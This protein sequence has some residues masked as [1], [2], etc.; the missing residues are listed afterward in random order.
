[1]G[2]KIEF[3]SH[4]LAFNLVRRTVGEADERFRAEAGLPSLRVMLEE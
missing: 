4:N 2:E 1:M 3:E